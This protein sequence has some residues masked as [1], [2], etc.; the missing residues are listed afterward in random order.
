MSQ[1]PPPHEHD[2]TT[3]P[4]D[5]RRYRR[6]TFN[7]EGRIS[8][9]L[10]LA[11]SQQDITVLD[12]SRGGARI[13]SQQTLEPG[14]WITLQIPRSRKGSL[15]ARRTLTLRGRILPGSEQLQ[16]R[17]GLN[18]ARVEFA[19]GT[20]A[21][22][23]F[24]AARL[25]PWAGAL[26]LIFVAIQVG[27]LRTDCLTFFW[28][29]PVV[30]TYGI[31]VSFFL[32]S[33]VVI[34]CFFKPPQ[35]TDYEPTLSVIVACKNEEDSIYKTLKCIYLSDY[36]AAKMQVISVNDGSTDAT[37]A[38][39]ERCK[40]E[41]PDLVIIDFPKNLGKRHGMAAGAR[42]ATGEVLVYI[43]SDSFVQRDTMREMA[44]GFADPDVGAVCGHAN[45]E[46]AR[47]NFL[48][49]MQEVRYYAAF[50]VV[51]AAESIF[52][53]VTCCS[54]CLAAYRR[55]YVMEFLD[56][57]LDQKFMGQEATFGDDRSL[58][59]Y[60]LRRWKVIYNPRAICTTIVPESW[61]VFFKQQ[62]RWKKSW[63]RESVTVAARF[64]WRRHPIA[65][66]LFY[67]G[68][69]FSLLSPLVVANSLILPLILH[70]QLPTHYIYGTLLVSALYGLVYFIRFRS[71]LWVYAVFSSLFY[72]FVLVWQTWYAL[73][74][75][76]RNHW[77]TR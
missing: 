29:H 57:W 47:T 53:A 32:L 51:K 38:E 49:K 72:M 25:A 10:S 23:G 14:E 37:L 34:A 73:A 16:H 75:V 7:A 76:H 63:I 44:S 24:L 8:G 39:M 11:S 5:R 42:V 46:N 60:M 67:L 66:A 40:S 77:G 4:Q 27:V 64:M 58:T 22:L 18:T 3:P 48:T 69:I 6:H 59:N 28:Y 54:G 70:R 50:R 52:S 56:I 21:R 74:T 43:D 17:D 62:L 61:R 9:R 55:D 20:K 1:K 13:E 26:L 31:L 36:P 68:M 65:A 12:I 41:H 30:N 35:R 45:V 19:Q 71:R 15:A 33:R 2:A